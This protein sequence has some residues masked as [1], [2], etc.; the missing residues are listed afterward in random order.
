[1]GGFEVVN[2]G[3][4]ALFD[5]TLEVLLPDPRV[6][7]VVVSG[8]I[9]EGTA[10]VW[11]DLDVQIVAE[12]DAYEGFLNEWPT[13]L[14]AI[15]ATAFART[16][17]APFIINTVTS[18]GLTFDLA[19]FAGRAPAPFRAEGYTVG[20]L[21]RQPQPTLANALEYA[22]AEQL[23]GLAGPFI[24]L[25]RRNEHMRH[26]TGLPHILGLLTTVFLAENEAGPPGKLWNRTFNP[27]QQAAVAALPAV[28]ATREDI[29]AFGLGLAELLVTRARPLYAH[30]S[31]TWPTSF[32]SVVAA[33]LNRDLG[34]DASAWL[35]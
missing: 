5:R 7:D 29:M 4:R 21:S 14:S 25:L 13:W 18:D 19:V 27:E 32:A 23:R 30:Y 6:R 2:P 28:R 9:A 15:T 31:L 35:H 8:S 20:L 33:R 11:S 16:P 24:T 26:L 1:V 34:V 22:V 12:V 10:D 17:I 3:Y